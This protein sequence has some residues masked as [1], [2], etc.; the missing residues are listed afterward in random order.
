MKVYCLKCLEIQH[1]ITNYLKERFT[2]KK[3]INGKV[4]NTQ[5]AVRIYDY[6]NQLFVTDFRFY[7][8]TLYKTKKGSYFLLKEG[9]PMSPVAHYDG[10][11]AFGGM[12]IE[13][14][15]IDNAKEYLINHQAINVYEN[16]FGDL[17]DA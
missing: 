10:Q 5:T 12:D 1:F 13:A 8:E 4:Y 9:G 6:D 16:E 11:N 14:L 3:I 17:E 2:M 7:S 15:T